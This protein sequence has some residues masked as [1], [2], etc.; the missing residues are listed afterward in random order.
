MIQPGFALSRLKAPMSWLDD[1][2]KIATVSA[3][4]SAFF[5]GL[6][7]H[8]VRFGLNHVNARVGVTI[9]SAVTA[10]MYLVLSPLW[11]NWEDA[12]NPAL[13]IFAGF[14]L[15]HPLLSRYM[16]YEANKRVGATISS[17][18]DAASPLLSVLFAVVVLSE[19]PDALTMFGTLLAVGG[20][21]YIY[22]NPAV[23][24]AS[25]RIAVCLALGA[26]CMRSLNTVVSKFGLELVQNPMMAAFVAYASSWVLAQAGMWTMPV[27]GMTSRTGLAWFVAAGVLTFGGSACM[28]TAL[29]YGDVVVVAPILAGYP[30]FAL[31]FGWVLRVERLT[32]SN[33][34]GVI[35]ILAGILIVTTQA[36]AAEH[37]WLMSDCVRSA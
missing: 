7:I 4:C 33:L 22:W 37:L 30:L 14:A 19:R 3:I 16:A 24:K 26:M 25:M 13:L 32:P 28:Y 15:L 31:C 2:I 21:L 34:V 12:T 11:F 6:G 35:V 5:Y 27:R 17:T 36:H 18:F 9:S 8:M 23:A 20:A 1:P 29:L 10:V